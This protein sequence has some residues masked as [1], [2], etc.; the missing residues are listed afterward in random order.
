MNGIVRKCEKPA[1]AQTQRGSQ[2]IQRAKY[3]SPI[4]IRRKDPR[5]AGGSGEYY[6]PAW[7]TRSPYESK[8]VADQSRRKRTARLPKSAPG[9]KWRAGFSESAAR[10]APSQTD[11]R[12][13]HGGERCDLRPGRSLREPAAAAKSM[14]ES[15][16]RLAAGAARKKSAAIRRHFLLYA[17]TVATGSFKRHD[18]A[19][20]G[21]AFDF[22]SEPHAAV[23]GDVTSMSACS[24]HE[25]P[26]QQEA[27][28]II[29]MNLIYGAFYSLGGAGE[30]YRFAA[31]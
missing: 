28:G 27:L 5:L 7:S 1:H 9:R 11:F 13:R 12:L 16:I 4:A 25:S 3:R 17:D 26:R 6:R 18:E 21:W 29:G 22:Q 30:T 2:K 19:M 14:L 20:A 10:P 15:R 8:G 31:R 23:L 24:T